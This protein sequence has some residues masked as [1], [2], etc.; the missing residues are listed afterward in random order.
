MA[1]SCHCSREGSHPRDRLTELYKSPNQDSMQNQQSSHLVLIPSG[2]LW[3]PKNSI[4]FITD[5]SPHTQI[6]NIYSDSLSKGIFRRTIRTSRKKT[7][8]IKKT[9]KLLHTLEKEA[10]VSN[11]ISPESA[12]QSGFQKMYSEPQAQGE[13]THG[14][15]LNMLKANKSPQAERIYS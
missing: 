11:I 9:I 4:A 3:G 7:L 14:K 1:Q 13:R 12:S 2:H 8:R 10:S 15:Y 5:C 6:I